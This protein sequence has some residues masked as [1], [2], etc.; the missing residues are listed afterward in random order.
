MNANDSVVSEDGCASPILYLLS[1]AKTQN[2]R[3]FARALLLR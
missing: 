2:G 1:F 3:E